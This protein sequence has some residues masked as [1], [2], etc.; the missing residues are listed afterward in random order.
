[1]IRLIERLIE[2]KTFNINRLTT[3]FSLHFWINNSFFLFEIFSYS[4][5]LFNILIFRST[6]DLF[7]F[8]GSFNSLFNDEKLKSRFRD[9]FVLTFWLDFFFALRLFWNSFSRSI[10]SRLLNLMS[11]L[12][13]S[14]SCSSSEE[15]NNCLLRKKKVIYLA[16]WWTTSCRWTNLMKRERRIN[17]KIHC[18]SQLF[19]MRKA[20]FT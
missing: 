4:L 19:L 15:I 5:V 6:V 16:F 3:I 14:L 10:L 18:L 8:L 9:F 2:K 11:F 1:M 13:F 17:V 20:L 7:S 12:L